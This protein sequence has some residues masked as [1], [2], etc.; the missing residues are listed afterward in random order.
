MERRGNAGRNSGPDLFGGGDR[1][2]SDGQN[3][4][5]DVPRH[6]AIGAVA[7]AGIS[8]AHA[9]RTKNAL[10]CADC[11]RGRQMLYLGVPI[12]YY[13]CASQ[14]AWIGRVTCNIGRCADDKG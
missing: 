2:L 11:D 8:G 1:G 9:G 14:M 4:L 7:G 12:G 3:R 5:R 10:K 13:A 6:D